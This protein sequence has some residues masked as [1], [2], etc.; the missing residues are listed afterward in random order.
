[1][2]AVFGLLFSGPERL[3]KAYQDRDLL[4]FRWDMRPEEWCMVV[5]VTSA[6]TVS[7]LVERL[8][9]TPTA[10]PSLWRASPCWPVCARL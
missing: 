9:W 10:W 5:T 8:L 1:M 2:E 6:T 7:C 4:L 3:L